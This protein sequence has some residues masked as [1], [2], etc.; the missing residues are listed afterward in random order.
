MT[1]GR[2]QRDDPLRGRLER[3][4][5]PG[6]GRLGVRSFRGDRGLV[7]VGR[8]S[9]PL[10]AKSGLGGSPSGDGVWAAAPCKLCAAVR[11]TGRRGAHRAGFSGP[12]KPGWYGPLG[13]AGRCR[14]GR[15]R[16]RWVTGGSPRGRGGRGRGLPDRSPS[17]GRSRLSSALTHPPC[18]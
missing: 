12:G 3:P 16:G 5:S 13:S 14:C 2:E 1:S 15:I 8:W 9:Q 18:S 4:A 6:A 10:N 11:G 17:H 7:G